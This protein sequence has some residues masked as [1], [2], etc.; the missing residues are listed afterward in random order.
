MLYEREKMKKVF[1]NTYAINTILNF[2]YRIF[3]ISITYITIP[4]TLRYLDNERYGIWQTILTIISWVAL[5]NF[6]IGNGLRNKITQSL[7]EKRYDKLKNYITS[8]YIYLTVIAIII[9]FLAIGLIFTV[10]TSVLFKNN[11]LQRNEIVFSFVIIITSFCVNFILGICSNIAY[12]I[13]K[14]SIVNLFQVIS[15]L[16]TLGGLLVIYKYTRVSL[17][18]ISLLY[19]VSNTL[20][21]IIFTIYIF[22]DAK[23]RPDIKH[24]NAVYGKELT[25]LGIEFFILQMSSIIL[26]STDNFIISTFI[27]VNQVTDYSIVS[28]LFQVIS[29]LFSILLIQLWSEVAKATY[30]A[31]YMWIKSSMQKLIIL[32]IP[33]AITLLVMIL[34]FDIISKIW[35]GKSII[36]DSKLLYL[37]AF[38]SWLICLNGIFVNIQNGMSK[39]RV[40]TISSLISC[41]VNIPLAVILIK[42]FNL[43]VIGVMMSNIICL[44]ISTAMCSID[45]SVRINSNNIDKIKIEC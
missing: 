23:L 15:N 17:I 20:T 32:L 19:F 14:S 5:T 45:V 44:M 38:Y 3:S 11:T 30:N 6:G 37:A 31:N 12:G 2:I 25:T 40:Q 18:N 1:N 36:V 41:I 16:L 34:K 33:T 24:R 4:L 8:A 42:F 21:N 35:L 10:N 13:H 7:T 39:I 9:L 29:T 27:G 43:G 28:K 26:F 22:S